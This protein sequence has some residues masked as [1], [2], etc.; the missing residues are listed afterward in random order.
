MKRFVISW[1]NWYDHDLQSK[2]V[3]A[4]NEKE[5]LIKCLLEDFYTDADTETLEEIVKNSIEDL[6]TM[7]FNADGMINAIEI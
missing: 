5:A 3:E 2:I 1:I 7:A 6:K 4:D